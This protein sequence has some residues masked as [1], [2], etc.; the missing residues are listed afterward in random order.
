MIQ[1]PQY[2]A[3]PGY[4]LFIREP[5]T[6][7]IGNREVVDKPALAI[8]FGQISMT[9]T[10]EHG[11]GSPVMQDGGFGGAHI[12]NADFTSGLFDTD[13]EADKQRWSAD[14]KKLVEETL[15]DAVENPNSP[16]WG[17]IEKY[18][19]PKPR[20]PWST[21]DNQTPAQIVKLADEVGLVS[22]AYQYESLTKKR[23][24]LLEDLRSLLT[25]EEELTAA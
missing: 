13:E 10:A 6:K 18:E 3:N 2:I 20:A 5:I 15:K 12:L 16:A 14:D 4:C 8:H 11:D 1:I 9:T 24:K 22:E 19:P 21:Y 25:Q 7:M 17:D 23:A